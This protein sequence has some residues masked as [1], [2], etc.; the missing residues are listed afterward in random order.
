M[1]VTRSTTRQALLAAAA[2]SLLALLS[3]CG[4]G[5]DTGGSQ[6]AADETSAAPTKDAEAHTAPDGGLCSV[7]TAAQISTAIGAT[8]TT[9]VGPFDACEFSQSDL[10]ALSG[11]LGTTPLTDGAGG[12]DSYRSGTTSAMTDSTATDLPGIGEAAFVTLGTIGG[13]TSLQAAGAAQVGDLLV[14]VNLSQGVGQ[15]AQ[16]LTD[17]SRALLVLAT[18]AL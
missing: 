11:S 16:E 6:A 3:G 7:I 14:T 18:D 17:L 5:S 9:E 1:S 10:R 2:L 12:Y 4:G 15:T 8:V 13:G